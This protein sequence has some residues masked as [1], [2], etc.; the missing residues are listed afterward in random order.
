[1]KNIVDAKHRLSEAKS[2][3]EGT[4]DTKNM[5][6]QIHTDRHGWEIN[7]HRRHGTVTADGGTKG[8]GH[9]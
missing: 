3:T 2:T 5:Q 8:A 6:P 9:R 4:E 7:N 1:M